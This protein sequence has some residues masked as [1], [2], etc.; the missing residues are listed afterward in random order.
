MMTIGLASIGASSRDIRR[1][2]GT[3]EII[4]RV[5]VKDR[6]KTSRK[7]RAGTKA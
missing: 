5:D 3:R 2:L 4:G 7:H 6:T 1:F